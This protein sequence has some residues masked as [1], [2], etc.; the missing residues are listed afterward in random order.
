MRVWMHQMLALVSMICITAD[1]SLAQSEPPLEQIAQVRSK[2]VPRAPTA[3]ASGEAGVIAKTKEWT[4]GLAS[5]TPPAT[6]LRFAAEHSR[7]I[8]QNGNARV[9]AMVTGG[10]TE[11]VKD[12]LY[13][14]GVDVAITH[15]DVLEHFKDVEKIPN[16]QKRVN[17]I[18][19]L[20]IS[21]IHVLVRPEINSFNDLEGKKI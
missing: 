3:E 20:Y 17:F 14:K 16:I 1:A 21:E 12:L 18:S 8:N 11:N 6:L 13:L 2:S 15:A 10:A 5:G 4:L 9:L 7:N 19:E